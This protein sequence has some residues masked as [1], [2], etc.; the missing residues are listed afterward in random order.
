M[1]M[2]TANKSMHNLF[3][4]YDQLFIPHSNVYNTLHVPQNDNMACTPLKIPF[5]G[6]K[7]GR[8]ATDCLL[9]IPN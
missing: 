3:L 5:A 4:R 2:R 8:L 6:A 9:R 1:A 7:A